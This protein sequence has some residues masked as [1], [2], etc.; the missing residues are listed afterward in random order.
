MPAVCATAVAVDHQRSALLVF[1]LPSCWWKPGDLARL[2][3]PSCFGCLAAQSICCVLFYIAC[4]CSVYLCLAF[5]DMLV[6][7]ILRLQQQA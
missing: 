4:V 5:V 3:C 2:D 7:V 1:G 6:L